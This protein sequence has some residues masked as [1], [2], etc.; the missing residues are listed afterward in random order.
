MDTKKKAMSNIIYSTLDIA[1]ATVIGYVFWMAMGKLLSPEYYGVLTTVTVLY[2]FL[3]FFLTMNAP[4]VLGKFIPKYVLDNDTAKAQASITYYLFAVSAI[5][6]TFS[7]A[8]YIFSGGIAATFYSSPL[9]PEGLRLLAVLT[10]F[11]AFAVF[12]KGALYGFQNLKGMFIGDTVGGFVKLAVSVGLVAAGFSFGGIMGMAAGFAVSAMLQIFLLF[13][14]G[15]RFN[16]RKELTEKAMIVYGGA[17]VMTSAIV[18]ALQNSGTLLIGV[19]KGISDAGLF[20]VGI[21][22]GSVLTVPIAVFMTATFPLVSG[23]LAEG[24]NKK[25]GVIVNGVIKYVFILSIPLLI[26]ILLTPQTFIL[27]IYTTAYLKASLSAGV[28]A[29][30][31]LF[32]AL[33]LFFLQIIFASGRPHLRTKT[34]AAA[35][36]ANI[37]LTLVLIPEY[38][39]EGAAFSFLATSLLL[40]AISALYVS[41]YVGMQFKFGW[42]KAIPPLLLF[43]LLVAAINA[44][45]LRTTYSA[46]L[47]FLAY[48]V[49]FGCLVFLKFFDENDKIMMRM[50]VEKTMPRRIADYVLKLLC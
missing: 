15:F 43:S 26:A 49:F 22:F 39:I 42:K 7:A 18:F 14:S 11:G 9:M 36:I 45:G 46:A 5:I 48:I 6:A 33:S 3:V 38:G 12:F 30:G 34:I 41:K 10:F 17:S 44:T 16:F 13:N 50:A 40:C 47:L 32:F 20:G 27:M 8:L 4:E 24:G 28:Y 19:M 2:G 25:V 31:V 1:V 29:A 21:L 37:A 23:L 35:A